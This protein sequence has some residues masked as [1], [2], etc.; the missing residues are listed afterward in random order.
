MINEQRTKQTATLALVAIT[1]LGLGAPAL[2]AAPKPKTY[3][4]GMSAEEY[5]PAGGAKKKVKADANGDP[6]LT[7][8]AGDSVKFAWPADVGDTHDVAYAKGGNIVWQT[9]AFAT[10][11][12]VLVGPKTKSK[13]LNGKSLKKVLLKPGNYK[14]YCTFHSGTMLMKVVVKK[15][16][17]K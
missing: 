8:V 13:D 10:Q 9:E 1:G 12:S 3:T 4:I 16:P 17:K 14:L 11:A 15:A 2:A 5:V 6:V 7:I